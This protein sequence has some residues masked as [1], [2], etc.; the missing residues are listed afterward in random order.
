V[1]KEPTVTKSSRSD[2]PN[3][4]FIMGD[5]IGWFNPSCYNLGTMGYQTP[6]IDR[7]ANEGALFT[8]WYGQQSCTA[9]RAAFITGQSP[10]RTGLT[11]VGLPGAKLGLGPDDPSIADVLKTY[12]YATGQFGKNHLGDRDE[13]LPTM[14]GFDEFFG[15]LYHLNAEEE[16]YYEDYPKDPKFREKYG[17]RGVLH[18]WADG[19]G[20][21]KIENTG[22]MPKERMETV[23]EEFLAAAKNFITRK[24]AEGGPWF[25]YFNSTRMHV[26]T[27]LKKDSRGV[28]GLGIYPDGMVEHD[29]HVG[30]LL[31]LLDELGVADNT[32]VAYTT[33]NG[34]ETCTFPDGG[35]TPF[36]GEKATNFEGGFRVPC[37]L[38]WPGVIKPGQRINDICAHEDFIPTFAAAAGEPDLVEKV[39]KGHQLNGKTFKVHL[40]GHN[41]LPFLSGK[42][43]AGPR[44]G[45]LYW[46]DD[47]DL[48]AIRVSEWKITFMEQHSQISPETPVSVWQ[49]EFS[50]VRAPL[51]YNIK[52]DPFER[53]PESFM[54][55]R[56]MAEHVWVQVPVQ[57]IVA[58]WL[59]SFKEFPPRAKAASFTVGDVMDKIATASPGRN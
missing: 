39:T 17:P 16:P 46:S 30:E 54:Y 53:G 19:K 6:N 13:H 9:G 42:E 41:L 27:H 33:D 48:L 22:P 26:F 34:A 8:D 43:K 24:H 32:I 11:K 40:D 7:I 28:T 10:I 25:C 59:E 35:A 15:N 57:A 37:A 55:G 1:D 44:K 45:F 20:G 21:Q 52:S 29:G 2:K 31:D 4:L 58:K 23:D 12:G 50:R 47:G 14:H 49:G 38:R 36:R 3:I 5:D 56:W 18:C 51:L